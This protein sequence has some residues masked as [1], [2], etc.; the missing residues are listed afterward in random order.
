MITTNPAAASG[1]R[2][3]L[4]RVAAGKIRP[5]VPENSAAPMNLTS[6]SGTRS[7]QAPYLRSSA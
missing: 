2:K 5:I 1:V 6:P 7:T 3:G 4:I